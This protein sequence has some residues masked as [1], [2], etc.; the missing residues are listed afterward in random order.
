MP[1]RDCDICMN[2]YVY[3][4]IFVFGCEES[5]K[6][7]YE[8]FAE[9]CRTNMNSKEVLKCALCAYQLQEGEIKQLRIPADQKREFVDYQIQKTFGAYASGRGIIRCPNKQCKW[10]A[11]A[12]DPNERFQVECPLCHHQFCS[13]CNAQYHFRTTCQELPEL[14]QRWFFWCN[15]GKVF[16][17]KNFILSSLSFGRTW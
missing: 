9:S 2:S 11:E 14:T 13:L 10:V 16:M 12:R 3:D 4:D 7:C 8:C 6:V 15:T 17:N 1:T 5:H